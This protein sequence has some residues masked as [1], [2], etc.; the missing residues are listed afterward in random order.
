MFAFFRADVPDE[1]AGA[2]G[3][4]SW[5]RSDICFAPVATLDEA[6]ADPQLRHRGM[7]VEEGGWRFPGPPIKLSATP[8]TI[9]TPPVTLGQHTDAVLRELGHD[10]AAIARLHDTGAV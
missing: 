7:V 8:A 9:R 3:R 6:I 1:D 2:N 5:V 10:D 4:R